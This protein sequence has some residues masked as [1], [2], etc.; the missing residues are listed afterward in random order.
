MAIFRKI[1]TSI[2]SDSFF[3]ELDKDKKLF[4]GLDILREFSMALNS[5][6]VDFEE[7]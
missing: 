4:Y 5:F 7:N 1:H 3:S 2:W 6:M